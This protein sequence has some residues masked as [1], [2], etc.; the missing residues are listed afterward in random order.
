MN[1]WFACQR[2]AED[3]VVT[4]LR[5]WYRV[6]IG[7][8]LTD[9][10]RA[11]GVE[12]VVSVIGV[13]NDEGTEFTALLRF[14]RR[15]VPDLWPGTHGWVSGVEPRTVLRQCRGGRANAGSL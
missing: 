5:Y 10:C 8:Q 11:C 15:C 9:Y 7:D 13:H 1:Y 12:F 6:Y 3:Q 2:C 14:G 4:R